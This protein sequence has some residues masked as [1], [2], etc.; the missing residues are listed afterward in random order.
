MCTQIVKVRIQWVKDVSIITLQTFRS[1]V[2]LN[3]FL[4]R[5]SSEATSI[6]KFI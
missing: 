6:T 2:C 4:H 3:N 1:L 5:G